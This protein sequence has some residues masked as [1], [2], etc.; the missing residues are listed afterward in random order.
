MWG[1]FFCQENAQKDLKGKT[2]FGQQ[3]NNIQD[4][5]EPKPTNNVTRD[6]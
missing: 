3:E 1:L 2:E 4:T 5:A 6:T